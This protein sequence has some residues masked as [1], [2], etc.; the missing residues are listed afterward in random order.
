MD[1]AVKKINGEMQKNP[2]DLYT[3]IVGHYIIDRCSDQSVADKVA[4]PDKSLSGAMGMIMCA[5][6]GKTKSNVAVLTPAEVF[7]AVDRYLGIPEDK[8]AQAAAMM[9]AGGSVQAAPAPDR[10]RV[11]LDLADFL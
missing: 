6:R 11:D 10:G 8:A 1:E 9:S 3:E 4:K 7:G 2:E 5:A